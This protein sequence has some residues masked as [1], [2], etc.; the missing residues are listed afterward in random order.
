[1]SFGTLLKEARKIKKLS[2]ED[3]AKILGVNRVSISNYEKDK[4]TPTLANLKKIREALDLSADYFEEDEKIKVKYIPLIGL[5]SCGIPNTSYHDD[6]EYIPVSPDIARDGVYAVCADGDSMLP[7]ITNG[8]IIICDK[9]MHC[10]HGNIVHYTHIDGESGLK[11]YLI[12][13]KGIVTLMPLNSNYLP[14]MCDVQD[15]RCARAF[16]IVSDLWYNNSYNNTKDMLWTIH[17][18]LTL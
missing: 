14:I 11:K 18:M 13:D 15:L 9:E 8:D 10:D 7:K 12:D 6:M 3:L 17:F 5:A 16:K 4:N 1:M 2:Q